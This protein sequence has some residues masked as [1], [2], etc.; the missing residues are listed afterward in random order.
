M[1]HYTFTF[2]KDD[3]DVE[4]KTT[5]K[6]AIERQFQI[7]VTCASVYTYNKENV[8]KGTPLTKD[9]IKK[10]I[11][12]EGQTLAE[13]RRQQQE[14]KEDALAKYAEI[15]RVKKEEELKEAQ[16]RAQEAIFSE[17]NAENQ[18]V[19]EAQKI[20][21]E[22]NINDKK[23]EIK[24][25]AQK[26]QDTAN[27]IDELFDKPTINH[28]D[29]DEH[30]S[31]PVEFGEILD[32]KMDNISYE[33]QKTRDDRFLKIIKMKD[34]TQKLEYLLITAYYLSEF[35][36]TDRFTVKQVNAKL[37]QNLDIVI[38]HEVIQEAVNKGYVEV[39]PDLTEV[40]N[41]AEYRLTDCGEE[42][43]LNG[44]E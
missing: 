17:K 38:D 12:K 40:A 42:A 11:P 14:A 25:E 15:Q 26:A 4:F 3:I 16:K 10:V 18:D 31:N 36:K 41:V 27:Q 32:K 24:I 9:E 8:L 37:M 19:I 22:K 44:T 30:I 2:K 29:V 1:A 6:E 33:P 35:E 5:N 7:W 34:A 23:E 43:F 13:R 28:M 21:D 20:D 39:I